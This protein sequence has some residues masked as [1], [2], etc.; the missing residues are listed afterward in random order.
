MMMG[1]FTTAE[2]IIFM[3]RTGNFTTAARKNIFSCDTKFLT[4][5]AIKFIMTEIFM[6][7]TNI[8]T[9]ETTKMFTVTVDNKSMMVAMEIFI[10][11][12]KIFIALEFLQR[13][14]HKTS[15]P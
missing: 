10:T 13:W 5:V 8:F 9:V 4:L 2:H 12:H 3:A 6:M 11:G 15:L 14:G 1:D 7:S